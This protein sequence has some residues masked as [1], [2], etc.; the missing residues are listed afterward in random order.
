MCVIDLLLQINLYVSFIFYGRKR[1]HNYGRST[2]ESILFRAVI[3]FPL[4]QNKYEH[5]FGPYLLYR[6]EI[7]VLF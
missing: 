1:R 3:V 2:F 6:S 4:S 5:A 7:E